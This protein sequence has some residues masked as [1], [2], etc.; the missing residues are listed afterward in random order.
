MADLEETL[1]YKVVVNDD[2][3]SLDKTKDSS[4]AIIKIVGNKDEN[5]AVTTLIN[6]EENESYNLNFNYVKKYK[7]TLTYNSTDYEDG[8]ILVGDPDDILNAYKG[9]GSI[10]INEIRDDYYTRYNFKCKLNLI[11]VPTIETIN[12]IESSADI[13]GN[14][15]FEKEVS[16]DYLLDIKTVEIKKELADKNIKYL[17]DINILKNGQK[18]KI[19]NVKMKIKIALP[20]YLKG[21]KK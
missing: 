11:A 9:S 17:V 8:K 12:Y 16:K 4:E 14:I 3:V 20:E 19:D 5:K 13:K 2:K 6:V 1:Y 15:T 18:V 10:I 21:Y 7:S